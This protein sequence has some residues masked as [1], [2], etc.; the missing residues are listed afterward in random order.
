MDNCAYRERSNS[1]LCFV[2][3]AYLASIEDVAPVFGGL[4]QPLPKHFFEASLLAV[5]PLK[6]HPVGVSGATAW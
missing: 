4:F 5:R 1:A 6:T 2:L 3:L